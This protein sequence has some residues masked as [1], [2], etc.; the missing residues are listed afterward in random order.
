MTDV[1]RTLDYI[2]RHPDAFAVAPTL[3]AFV[4]AIPDTAA[5]RVLAPYV[6]GWADLAYRGAKAHGLDLTPHRVLF[7][8][9][10]RDI[11]ELVEDV[12]Y[13][14]LARCGLYRDQA[15][16]LVGNRTFVMSSR[17]PDVPFGSVGGKCDWSPDWLAKGEKVRRR[18]GATAY[19]TYCRP[20]SVIATG[21]ADGGYGTDP[22]STLDL[23][24]WHDGRT[25]VTARYDDY[26]GTPWLAVLDAGK[27][28]LVALMPEKDREIIAENKRAEIEAWGE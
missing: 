14:P 21:L 9:E 22:I 11:A 23:V 8:P 24:R 17:C 25:L 4:A 6:G 16:A 2:R 5:A 19:G 15:L 7:C 28:D 20:S 1:S 10:A 26:P 18:M 27:C 3:A 13:L 12:R